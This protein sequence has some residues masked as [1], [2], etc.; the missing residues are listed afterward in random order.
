MLVRLFGGGGR[1][2]RGGG[3]PLGERVPSAHDVCAAVVEARLAAIAG[4][5][6]Q[7]GHG[8]PNAVALK[9]GK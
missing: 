8:V 6:A 7:A 3:L 9:G 1:R 2:L 5:G 4:V